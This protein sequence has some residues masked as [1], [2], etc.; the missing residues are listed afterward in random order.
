[1]KEIKGQFNTAKVFASTVEESC[2]DQILEL[3]N[4]EWCKNSKIRNMADCHSGKGCVIG[5]TMT[6]VDK[7]VPNMVGVDGS[8]GM[9]TVKLGNV[10]ID[11]EHLDKVIKNNIP[12]GFNRRKPDENLL[13]KVEE[14]VSMF[15]EIDDNITNPNEK[16]IIR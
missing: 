12:M 6:I 9:L 7:L 10:D 8:C 11:L 14:I 1:M 3:C 2:K 5:T 4:Q 15:Y 16:V 13:K